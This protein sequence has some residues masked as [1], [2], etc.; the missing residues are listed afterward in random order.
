MVSPFSDRAESSSA[1]QR[2]LLS[3]FQE[4]WAERLNAEQMFIL[5]DGVL[6]FEACLYYQI[7][8]LFIE[9]SRLNLGMVSPDDTAAV[10]Y[11][12]RILSYMNYSLVSRPISSEAL[13]TVLSA[14][15]HQTGSQYQPLEKLAQ[16]VRPT[17]GA[18]RSRSAQ[19]IDRH[20]QQTLVVD[21][22]EELTLDGMVPQSTAP[23]PEIPF[24]P[25]SEVPD[26]AETVSL[27]TPAAIHASEAIA[28]EEPDAPPIVPPS[29][30][31]PL[32]LLE[33]QTNY[34]SSPVELLATLP[35]A[36]LLKELLARVLL[37]G[38]GR[39]Y[40]ERQ[41]HYGR[42]LWSQNG[43][44]QSVIDRLEPQQFQGVLNELKRMTHL[45]LIPV[46]Q[47]KQVEIERLYQNTRLLL[48]FRV[49]PSVNG[50]E[51]ATLQVLR[52]AALRFYQQQQLSR[53]E[54]DAI[55]IAKQL[56]LKVNEIRDRAR[57]QPGS[58]GSKFDGLPAL[59]QMLRHIEEQIE[60]LQISPDK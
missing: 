1:A 55:S 10:D 57:V 53:L 31:A 34:L 15:L 42:V 48:R 38:I 27:A 54:R 25:I 37:G 60:D 24:H 13:Q 45:S 33:V 14:Y 12:R 35:P 21:S 41:P 7:L 32:P 22:P 4:D 19:S 39:L 36:T 3:C 20:L 9:G 50:E 30:L 52:G 5:I 49:M 40:F 44:L 17:R 46:Q 18:T 23:P 59:N 28:T 2:H 16:S 43:V 26:E 56:Q 8:P 47:P 29:V 58:S 11:V 6:P 51:E